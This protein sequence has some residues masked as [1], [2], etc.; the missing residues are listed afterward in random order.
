MPVV[1]VNP[2]TV[3]GQVN[4]TVAARTTGKNFRQMQGEVSDWN[5]DAPPPLVQTWLNNAYRTIIDSRLWYGL[6]VRGEIVVPQVYTQGTAT[7]TL[8]SDK[9]QGIGTGWTV[10]MVGMQIRSGF[11]TGFYNISAVNPSTQELTLD[12]PWGN[13]T[14]TAA[15][16]TIMQV[17]VTLGYN[18]KLVLS[19]VNQ[20]QGYPLKI[21]V[22]QAYLNAVDTWRTTT[23]WTTVLANMPPDYQGRP[24]YELW[25][26]PTF[27]Q[28]F[29]FLAYTQ[30][31]DM[32]KDS[33]YP[34]TFVRSDVIVLG[35]IKDALLFK[36]RNSRYYDPNTSATK[37]RE[38]LDQIENMKKMDDNQYPK[39]SQADIPGRF[40]VGGFGS[41]WDQS[42]DQDTPW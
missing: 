36:G 30:T 12:L 16:Y 33:D 3:P 29:P 39:D 9:V 8:N 42:H 10:S 18:V 38:F 37:H 14:V 5:P 13:A 25:P 6:M 23:G 21:N 34:A 4:Q 35:A 7:F 20:R 41:V 11:S 31:P 2:I 15:G 19:A 32:V 27:Q 24:M 26:A 1:T 40:G 28:T 22:T 17:W